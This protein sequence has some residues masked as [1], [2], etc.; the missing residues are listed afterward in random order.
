MAAGWA[1]IGD[2]L[3]RW[4]LRHRF[5]YRLAD[6]QIRWVGS[7][8]LDQRIVSPA[9]Q[10]V[11]R[12]GWEE[13]ER[14]YREALHHQRGGPA[15]RDDALTSANAALEAALKAAALKGDRLSVLAKDLRNSDLIPGQLKSVPEAVD[16]FAEAL[17]GD[18]RRVR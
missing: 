2:R 10:A 16:T 4:L 1:D 14:T 18:P 7:P 8:A 15:E 9:L 11:H 6:G 3:N 5:G 12:P 13:T 17:G